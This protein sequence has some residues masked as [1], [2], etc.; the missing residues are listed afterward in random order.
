VSDD[1]T[2]PGLDDAWA[3]LDTRGFALTNEQAIGLSEDFRQNF[4]EAYFNSAV[5]RRDVGDMP[6][7]RERARDVIRYQWRDDGLHVQEHEIIT[8]TDRAGI[9]GQRD[10]KR[11]RLLDDPQAAELV[12]AFLSLV[13][14]SRRQSD[15]TFDVNL[16][17]TFTNVVS[18]PHCDNEQ[19]C[20]IYLLNRVGDGAETYLYRPGDITRQGQ[21]KAEPVFRHQLSPGEIVIFED[22]RFMHGAT[23]LEPPPG[24][25]ALRDA[26]VC[27]VDYRETYLA[28]A[29][30][31]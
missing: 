13:P 6:V 26:V 20:L 9:E 29:S 5:L 31:N 1:I 18:G 28:G 7:D 23:P 4:R 25:S 14:P 30:P 27:T 12:R 3:D 15:G 24:G 10:H 22:K 8:I 16:F 2:A 19:F 17:R 11:V 21:P